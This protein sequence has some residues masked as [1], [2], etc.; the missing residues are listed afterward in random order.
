MLSAW[1]QTCPASCVPWWRKHLELQ[2]AGMIP[3]G[4][5]L[6]VSGRHAY[7]GKIGKIVAF[8]TG[9]AEGDLACRSPLWQADTPGPAGRIYDAGTGGVMVTWR[10]G[11][12]RH[13]SR[14]EL[15]CATDGGT[16]SPTGSVSLGET[17]EMW[18]DDYE[19]TLYAAVDL[20]VSAVRCEPGCSVVWSG[21]IDRLARSLVAEEQG[22]FLDISGPIVPYS[23]NWIAAMVAFT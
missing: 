22:V 1:S 8:A 20:Q 5:H 14:F 23:L 16:C 11:W 7:D 6:F 12:E 21:P 15:D 13:V 2:Q 10:T 3:L 9:C 17:E 19:G 18:Q 4:G